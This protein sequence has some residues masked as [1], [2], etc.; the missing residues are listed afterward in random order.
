MKLNEEYT[1]ESN[2]CNFRGLYYY[3]FE[4]KVLHDSLYF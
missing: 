4:V 2:T 3:V 1:D